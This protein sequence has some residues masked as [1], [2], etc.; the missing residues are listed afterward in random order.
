MAQLDDLIAG[1]GVHSPGMDPESLVLTTLRALR[2]RP[3]LEACTL[4]RVEDGVAT[5]YPHGDDG[6]N[7]LAAGQAWR[8]DDFPAV[9]QAMAGGG[10]AVISAEDG[11]AGDKERLLDDRGLLGVVLAPVVFWDRLVG[12]LELG[13]SDPAGL[14]TARH[15]AQVAADLLAVA[16]GS[17]DVIARLQRRNRDLA[18]VVNAGLE[19]TARLSTDDILHAVVERLSELTHTP[20]ADI[21]T[22]EGETLHALVSYDN[23][24][25]EAEWSGVV[26]PLSRYPCTRRAIE[27][28]ELVVAASLD[29]PVLDEEA[30]YSLERWGYQAHL[31]MP[32][33][34]RGRVLGVVELSDYQPRDF[35][36]DLDLIRGLGQ[37]AAHALENASLFEQVERR[38]TILNELVE[39]GTLASSTRDLDKLVRTVAERVVS[40]V[41]AANCDVYR[42]QAGELI[43]VASFDRSGHD[44][45]VLGGRFDL[46]LYPTTVEAIYGHQILTISSPGDPQLSEAE[47]QT[48]HDY[49]FSSEV[50]LPLVVNDELFGLLDVYDTRERDYA[51]FLSFLR[52]AAQT[53]AGAFESGRLVDQLEQRGAVLRDIVELGAVAAQ[54]HDPETVL[55]ALA[56]RLRDTIDAADCDIFTLQGDR[57]RCLVSADRNGLDMTV[58]GHVLDIDR[59]PATALAVHTGQPMTIASLDDPKLTDQERDDMAEYGYQSE[60]CIPLVGGDRVIGLIDVFDT[61]PRDYGEYIDFLRSMGQT[62]AGAVENAMLLDKLER[63]NTA[64]AELVELGRAASNAGGLDQLV[65]SIGPRVVELMEADGCQVFILRGSNLHCVLTYDDGQFLDDYADRPLDLDLFPSTKIAIVEKSALIVAS[66]EDPRL[67]DYERSLYEESGT[68]SEICVPLVLEDRVVGLLD[69]YDHRRR[70]YAEHRDFLLRVGQ[71]MAGAFENA[72][73]MEQLEDSNQTLGLLV[74]SGMEFGATLDRDQ[75]LE[76]VARRLCAATS[77]PNCDI[78]TV[79]GDVIRRVAC[80]D[81]DAPAASR[82]GSEYPLEELGL[83]RL[84]LE[85]RQPVYAEDVATDPRVER[86]RTPRGPQLGAPLHAL[87]AAHQ[88]R[89][90]DRRGRHLRRQAGQ[91]RAHR[92]PPQPGASGRGRDGQ[93]HPVR[94]AGSQRRAHGSGQRRQLRAVVIAGPPGRAALHGRAPVRRRRRPDVRHLHPARWRDPRERHQPR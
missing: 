43:C 58:V 51:E 4:Y 85:S 68:Q 71:M 39:L 79:H 93:R 62:A 94:R 89:P 10:A 69:V 9:A 52:S 48:Y 55:T 91:V 83:A 88:S 35:S 59:F 21:Y 57:L 40:T 30:R 6:G 23:G 20:V 92:L 53:L 24:R 16:L 87:P 14:A 75:V 45:S 1:H 44:E 2:A 32:L 76:S 90:G 27:T 80:I 3:G 70:D 77:A 25:Y 12:A 47:R 22:V 36:D 17:G 73:L 74:E 31:S 84:A 82:I 50:C 41:D 5:P 63:R 8:L 65:R 72:L 38:N 26:V 42:M 54:A 11:T 28:G 7:P 19:D 56:E 78:F 64:L 18:L 61:R 37:V 29:D 81:H 86:A 15:V 60:L 46:D 33:S 49:G 66:P 34:V 13:S 67:S